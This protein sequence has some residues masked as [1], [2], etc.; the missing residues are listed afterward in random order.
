[1]ATRLTR[2]R[3]VIHM[4]VLHGMDGMHGVPKHEGEYRDVPDIYGDH[5]RQHKVCDREKYIKK[6]F[7][8][9]VA[10]FNRCRH[11]VHRLEFVYTI[12]EFYKAGGDEKC[13]GELE[14][15]V[16]IE[17]FKE[18]CKDDNDRV[19]DMRMSAV[20]KILRINLRYNR[21]WGEMEEADM[22]E[23]LLL[24]L[25]NRNHD[26]CYVLDVMYALF[27][28]SRHTTNAYVGGKL[29]EQ[30]EKWIADG[31]HAVGPCGGKKISWFV[32]LCTKNLE[33]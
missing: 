28:F 14:T 7:D 9:I 10:T 13:L 3:R 20:L 21:S 1:M 11:N 4:R 29:L 12:Y 31:V 19:E 24:L 18:L 25:Q 2:I 30:C 6:H 27:F 15:R 8:D 16:L 26:S 5:G 22:G 23:A 33:L 17:V 32:E